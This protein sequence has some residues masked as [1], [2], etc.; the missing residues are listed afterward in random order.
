MFTGA[1]SGMG[2]GGW[3]LMAVFWVGFV[4]LLVWAVSRIFPEGGR[5][6]PAESASTESPR[7]VLNRRLAAGEIDVD[8]YRRLLDQLTTRGG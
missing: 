2:V 8:T 6:G 7:E 1:C 3:V 4:A 5:S